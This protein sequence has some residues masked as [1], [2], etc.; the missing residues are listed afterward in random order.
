MNVV[1]DDAIIVTRIILIII[2][3]TLIISDFH[4]TSNQSCLIWI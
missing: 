2:A 1:V 3:I 4:K